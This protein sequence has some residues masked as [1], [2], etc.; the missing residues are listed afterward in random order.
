MMEAEIEGIGLEDGG[1]GHRAKK[2]QRPLEA[3]KGKEINFPQE[4]PERTQPCQHL[5]FSPLRL[6]L[7]F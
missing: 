7:D 6:I 4:P 5:D 1:K 3:K 2:C